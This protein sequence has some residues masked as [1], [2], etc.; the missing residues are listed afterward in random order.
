MCDCNLLDW[1]FLLL[2]CYINLEI[3]TATPN[4]CWVGSP[5]C[6]AN[7]KTQ[8]SLGLC[9]GVVII[10]FPLCDA[11]FH[12]EWTHVLLFSAFVRLMTCKNLQNTKYDPCWNCSRKVKNGHVIYIAAVLMFPL[13]YA[14]RQHGWSKTWQQLLGIQH[15]SDISHLCDTYSLINASGSSSCIFLNRNNVRVPTKSYALNF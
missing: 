9:C 14:G 1:A 5:C 15:V 2:C 3:R 11:F 12:I 13:F 10:I 8:L 6:S 7:N 4:K